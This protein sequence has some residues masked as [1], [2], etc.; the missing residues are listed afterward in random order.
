MS[1]V[2]GALRDLLRIGIQL[3]AIE[4]RRR[5]EGPGSLVPWLRVRGRSAERRSPEERVRLRRWITL[6][7]RLIPGPP[8]CYRRALLEIAL[9]AGAAEEPLHMGLKVPGGPRSGHAWL[10]S[11]GTSVGNYDVQFD[12]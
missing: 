1:G 11:D 8:N 10:G 5:T 7:D 2:A 12:I 4:W 6:V 9:D 3:P